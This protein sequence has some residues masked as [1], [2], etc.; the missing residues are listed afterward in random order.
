MQDER[1]IIQCLILKRKPKL[2]LQFDAYLRHSKLNSFSKK[3]FKSEVRGLR[4]RVLVEF[5][6]SKKLLQK[7]TE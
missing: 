6:S 4:W 1:A 2:S 3:K 5:E 7:D